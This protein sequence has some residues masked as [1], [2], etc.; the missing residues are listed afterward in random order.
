MNWLEE[1]KFPQK[2]KLILPLNRYMARAPWEI[3]P[4]MIEEILENGSYHWSK[5]ELTLCIQIFAFSH[6]MSTIALG[7]GLLPED[8]TTL[9]LLNLFKIQ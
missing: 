7:V 2:Y 4:E 9:S 1:C 8:Q 3:T 6:E 5:N